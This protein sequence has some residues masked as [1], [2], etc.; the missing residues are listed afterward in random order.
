MEVT[1]KRILG[2]CAAV[3]LLLCGCGDAE[4]EKVPELINA[5]GVDM[6]TVEVKKMDLSGV[7]SYSAQVIPKI[8]KLGFTSSGS[9]EDLKVSIGDHVKK[10]DLLATLAGASSGTKAAQKEIKALKESNADVNRQSQY[11]I[12]MKEENLKNLEKQLKERKKSSEKKMVENQIAEVKADIRI[13]KKKL[14]QQ[15]EMQDLELRQKQQELKSS[16]KSA[17]NTKLYSTVNGEVVATAGGAGYMVQGGSTAV[18]V[19]NMEKPRLKTK[20][21]PSSELAKASSYIAVVEGKEYR[22]EA[23]EQELSKE[24]I[25]RGEYPSNTW[26]DFVDE[27]VDIAVG[28]SAA[29]ELYTDSVKDALVVPVNAVFGTRE[30]HYVYLVEG[31]AKV[32]TTV[33]TGTKT[34]AYVQLVTGVEEGDVVYVEG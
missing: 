4:Q 13:A 34:D 21:I 10:G 16:A 3:A 22:I 12:E 20:Y 1:M 24:E 30:E 27:N 14:A 8:E 25:E 18:Q 26:F 7:T 33:T 6:D 31:G 11:D 9:I 2:L 19:A 23:E 5:V 15:K 17:K 28:K 32:K 29:V